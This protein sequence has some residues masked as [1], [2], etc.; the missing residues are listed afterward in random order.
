[1]RSKKPKVRIKG[2]PKIKRGGVHKSKKIYN[3][4]NKNGPNIGEGK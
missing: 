4:R 1:M 2:P 3:R